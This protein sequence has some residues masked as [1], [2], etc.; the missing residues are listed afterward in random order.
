MCEN[1]CEDCA[2]TGTEKSARRRKLLG[3]FVAILNVSVIA[4]VFGPV[5]GFVGS[6]LRKA[7]KS[8]WIAIGALTDFAD[9][10]TK[11]VS[12]EM[13]VHDGYRDTIRKYTVY[14][15]REG[16]SVLVFDPA[17]TH[18]GCRV[19]FQDSKQRYFCPC[20]GGVFDSSGNVV[21]GPPPKPLNQLEA[22][23]ENGR[24]MVL[25]QV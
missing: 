17:C 5:L 19:K 11:E 6:P 23:I 4:A 15:K 21:S 9:G 3:W 1:G 24:V 13:G 12:F 22:K 2:K 16:D 7:K 20:H 18:L 8:N 25:K 10:E 14:A